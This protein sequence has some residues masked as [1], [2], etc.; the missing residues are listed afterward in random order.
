LAV[1]VALLL[2]ALELGPVVVLELELGLVLG[3]VLVLLEL[4]HT[5][6]TLCFPTLLPLLHPLWPI[7]FLLLQVG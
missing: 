1:L 7:P 3:L 6:I 2:V 4:A 5:R